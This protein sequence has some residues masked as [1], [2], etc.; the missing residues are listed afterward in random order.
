MVFKEN[1]RGVENHKAILHY[2]RW[3]VYTKKKN[4]LFRVGI[5]CKCQILMVRRLFGKW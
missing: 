2:K 5:L 3:D 4:H 1:D